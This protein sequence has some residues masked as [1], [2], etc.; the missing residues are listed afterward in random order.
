MKA[1]SHIAEA[2]FEQARHAPETGPDLPTHK[3]V[4]I[5]YC[6]LLLDIDAVKYMQAITELT[7]VT[8]LS[9]IR[10]QHYY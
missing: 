4:N 8:T 2:E 5:N 10:L 6:Q 3:I 7:Y 9:V 1:V